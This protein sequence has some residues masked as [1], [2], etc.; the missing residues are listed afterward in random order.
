MDF[1][2]WLSGLPFAGIAVRWIAAA[3]LGITDKPNV[4]ITGIV[5][6]PDDARPSHRGWHYA[7]VENQQRSGASSRWPTK[8]A[9]QSIVKLH[10]ASGA[11]AVRVSA[12]VFLKSATEPPEGT[13][14]LITGRP[15]YVPV[16]LIADKSGKVD[17]VGIA[18]QAG[19]VY[20]TS[21]DWFH[22]SLAE[23]QR[24]AP[25]TYGLTVEVSGRWGVA[26][27]SDSLTVEAAR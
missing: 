12:G 13:T 20:I 23:Q 17:G 22:Q 15:R 19:G 4:V 5:A 14:T 16:Y 26:S 8:D 18:V 27:F 3:M 10:F 1:V 7:V 11:A 2:R 9:E 6:N 21:G 25:G 24:L